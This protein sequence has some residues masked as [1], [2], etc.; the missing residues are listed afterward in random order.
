[1]CSQYNLVSIVTRLG[2]GLR[3]S[4]ISIPER[5]KSSFS[6][7]K[8]PYRLWGPPSLRFSKWPGREAD[9]SPHKDPGLRMSGAIPLLSQYALMAYTR[10][11]LPSLTRVSVKVIIDGHELW[12]YKWTARRSQWPCGLR[13]GSS[14]AHLLGSWVRNPPGAWMSVC[15][16]CCVL[17]GRGFCDELV[18]RPE[19]SYRMWCV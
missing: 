19:E 6:T 13:R 12:F 4:R 1:M 16:E 7:P 15:C 8:G 9:N 17:S 11:T 14:V 3:R 18:P 2:G 5:G 10:S